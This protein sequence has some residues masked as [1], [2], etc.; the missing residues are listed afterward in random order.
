MGI[1]EKEKK[2]LTE[3]EKEYGRLFWLLV[4]VG[5]LLVGLK[6]MLL[7]LPFL[8]ILGYLSWKVYNRIEKGRSINI[9]NVESE[10]IIFV[11][12]LSSLVLV[13]TVPMISKMILF[14]SAGLALAKTIM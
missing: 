8:G 11:L 1:L 10:V 5:L 3:V 14:I 4:F 12:L 9:E 7:I 6:P 2:K 13:N